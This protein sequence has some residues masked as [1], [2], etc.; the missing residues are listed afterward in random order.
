VCAGGHNNTSRRL[1]TEKYD[2]AEDT[3]TEIPDM[4]FYEYQLIAEVMDD[5]ILAIS[6]KY[7]EHDF[8]SHISCFNDKENRWFVSLYDC[9]GLY[10][11][12]L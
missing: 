10:N 2:R 5:T 4:N 7:I 6:G 8:V 1:R 12:K 3:W 9:S 11:H